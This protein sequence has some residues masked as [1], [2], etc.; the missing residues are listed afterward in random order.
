MAWIVGIDEAGYG[1][2]LGP[3]VMTAV[4]CRVPERHHETCLWQVLRAA[5]RRHGEEPGSRFVVAD[6]KL[7]YA[8]GKGLADLER[9]A[10]AAGARA[11]ETLQH[12]VD[13]FCPPHA[14]ELRREPWYT[15]ATPL[16]VAA[17]PAVCLEAADAL[18]AAC[19]AQEVCWGPV[20]CVVVCPAA[21]NGLLARWGT[22]GAVLATALGQLLGR[23]RELPGPGDELRIFIDK[24]GGRNN[25][26]ATLQ[27]AFP[28]AMVLAAEEGGQRSTYRV[29]DSGRD[30][31]ITFEP[32]ADYNHFSVALASMVSKYLRELLMLEFNRFWSAKV[33]GIEP[34]AGYPGD[35]RRFW[36][37]IREAAR[38]L[39]LEDDALWRR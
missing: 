32:R 29:N 39:G 6:S 1:P 21:F 24:H 19:A 3:F 35:A 8:A 10:H 37:L 20:H 5:V 31:G 2:N 7:V 36:D 15:G 28:D 13:H 12:L 22:K 18:A 14:D 34:T 9:G 27:P 30:I 26:A 16:P 33:P 25:Y 17:D 38:R 11:L 23:L 4:A